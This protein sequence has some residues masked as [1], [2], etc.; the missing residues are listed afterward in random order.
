[1]PFG[2]SFQSTIRSNKSIMLDKTKR[3]RKTFGSFNWLKSGQFHFPKASPEQLKLIKEKIQIENR[4]NR[5]KQILLLSISMFLLILLLI[6][7]T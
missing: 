7:I 6:F 5:I 1:M 3:F 4:Q 2:E